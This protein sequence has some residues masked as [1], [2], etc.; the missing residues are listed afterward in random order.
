MKSPDRILDRLRKLCLSLPGVTEV[1]AWGHPNFRAGKKT[2]AVFEH[3]RGRP[4]IAFKVEEGMQELL[5]DEVRF[6]RT[7]YIGN[8]GW[9]SAWVDRDPDWALLK[10]LVRRSYRLMAPASRPR[11]KT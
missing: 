5:I 3:Y 7:P 1:E 11:R 9:V 2:F 6:F 8:R 4:S 10:K